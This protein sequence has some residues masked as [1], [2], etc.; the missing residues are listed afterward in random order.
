MKTC[1]RKPHGLGIQCWL[2]GCHS[3]CP[4]NCF[5]TCAGTIPTVAMTAGQK[6][7]QT[8]CPLL[9]SSQWAWARSTCPPRPTPTTERLITGTSLTAVTRPRRPASPI[10][11]PRGWAYVWTLR[12]AVSPFTM[13]IPSAHYG[14]APSTAPPPSAPRSAS[15]EEGLCSSRS[16]WPIATQIKRPSEESPYNPVSLN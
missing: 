1:R 8:L 2:K 4:S 12:R 14:R 13:L 7:L 9:P 11:S 5:F 10:L 15:S 3:N 16:W 6:T